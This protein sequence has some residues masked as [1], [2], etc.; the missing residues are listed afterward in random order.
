MTKLSVNINKVAT[1]R[2]ARGGNNPSMYKAKQKAKNR[3]A[4]YP[5]GTKVKHDMFGQG[6]VLNIDGNKLEIFFDRVGK[7]KLMSEYVKKA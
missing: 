1:L 2:N 4:V 3:N 7:K 6:T 5:V